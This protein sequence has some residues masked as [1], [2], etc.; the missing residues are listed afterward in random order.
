MKIEP[1]STPLLTNSILLP[2]ISGTN[3]III[4]WYGIVSTTHWWDWWPFNGSAN[5]LVGHCR[6]HGE[7][8]LSRNEEEIY[9]FSSKLGKRDTVRQGCVNL[10]NHWSS[11]I[12]IHNSRYYLNI[13]IFCSFFNKFGIPGVLGCI[14]GTHIE[15]V[16]PIL[17]EERYFCRKHYHSLNVQLVCTLPT[18]IIIFVSKISWK[19]EI[20]IKIYTFVLD[21]WFRNADHKCWCQSWRQ[22]PRFF[23]LE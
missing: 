19:N 16:R 15:I 9:S 7:L 20:I 17:H 5:G 23:Y 22:H 3:S 10:I 11:N 2:F 6:S 21:L 13:C 1:Y 12:Q 14:D 8:G 4:L 18:T